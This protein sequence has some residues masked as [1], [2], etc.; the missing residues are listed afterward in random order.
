M[1]NAHK[2]IYIAL[3]LVAILIMVITYF[4]FSAEQDTASL[5]NINETE[6]ISNTS[7]VV[8]IVNEEEILKSD[9]DHLLS[10]VA[11]QRGINDPTTID[12]QIQEQLESQVLEML[13]SQTLL[14]QA[15]IDSGITVSETDVDVRLEAIRDQ[16]E[17]DEEYQQALITENLTEPELRNKIAGELSTEPY[18]EKELNLSVVNASESEVVQAYEQISSQNAE[19]A[20]LE[21]VYTQIEELVIQQK[22]QELIAQLVSE[23]RADSEIEILI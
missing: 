13:I 7:D 2:K 10:Q 22:Q 17:S 1:H 9:F 15:V 18:L 20:P 12:Q 3:G 14:K 23:L 6:K 19:I 8:M 21:D 5:S 11:M 16:F 4:L